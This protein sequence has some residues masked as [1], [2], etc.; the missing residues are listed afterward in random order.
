MFNTKNN[1]VGLVVRV[2]VA[3][4]RERLHCACSATSVTCSTCMRQTT[5]LAKPWTHRLRPRHT[6][7]L[8]TTRG[9]TVTPVKVRVVPAILALVLTKKPEPEII[10]LFWPLCTG[11]FI[12]FQQHTPV[13]QIDI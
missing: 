3:G 1:L 9:R 5:V 13:L 2:M 4:L 6:T 7:C 8:A 10:R 12:C 11:L